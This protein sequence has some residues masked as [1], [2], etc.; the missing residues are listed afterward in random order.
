MRIP[1]IVGTEG[2]KVEEKMG[3]KVR[4][5][6]G[7]FKHMRLGESSRPLPGSKVPPEYLQTSRPPGLFFLCRFAFIFLHLVDLHA[8]FFMMACDP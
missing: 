8:G 7:R 5:N 3:T 1:S 6:H 4:G 2:I